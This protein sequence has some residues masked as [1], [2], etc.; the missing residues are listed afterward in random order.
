[1]MEE[2][3]NVGQTAKEKALKINVELPWYFLHLYSQQT[4]STSSSHQAGKTTT[5]KHLQGCFFRLSHYISQSLKYFA[6]KATSISMSTAILQQ[7]QFPHVCEEA[8]RQ[9]KKQRKEI[10]G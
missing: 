10:I 1:M 5:G 2:T 3:N 9:P 8:H 7:Q 4:F 6:V